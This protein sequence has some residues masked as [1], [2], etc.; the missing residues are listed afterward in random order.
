MNVAG[1]RT[2]ACQ[3]RCLHGAPSGRECWIIMGKHDRNLFD[4]DR[5]DYRRWRTRAVLDVFFLFHRRIR[6]VRSTVPGRRSNSR[7]FL[8]RRFACAPH[9]NNTRINTLLLVT[10]LCAIRSTALRARSA[11]WPLDRHYYSYDGNSAIFRN[12]YYCCPGVARTSERGV[13][14][15]TVRTLAALVMRPVRLGARCLDKAPKWCTG[16]AR[17]DER[18]I[19]FTFSVRAMP[20]LL[21]TDVGRPNHS[22]GFAPAFRGIRPSVSLSLCFQNEITGDNVHGISVFNVWL[23]FWR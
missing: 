19:I 20:K 13:R 2:R 23:T 15:A 7:A 14:T 16:E 6:L 5:T 17:R 8:S 12:D 3:M 11:T 18:R 22:R 4:R 9:G 1:S 21:G 10:C